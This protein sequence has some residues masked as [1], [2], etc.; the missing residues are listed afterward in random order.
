MDLVIAESWSR[1]GKCKRTT[2]FSEMLGS[3]PRWT[4]Q[5]GGSKPLKPR[6]RFLDARCL[7]TLD[8]N[9]KGSVAPKRRYAGIDGRTDPETRSK[10]PMP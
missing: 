5:K 10:P 2:Q 1:T 3:N 9:S 4:Y 8:S 7:P 6:G